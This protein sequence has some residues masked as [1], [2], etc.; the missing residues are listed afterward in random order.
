MTR[1]TRRDRA[2][3]AAARYAI[4]PILALPLPW[5]VHRAGF[6]LFAPRPPGDVRTREHRGRIA[7]VPVLTVEP[8]DR[9]GTL[10]W[11]HG[12]GFVVGSPK[13]NRAMAHALARR[14]GLRVILPDYRKAP[15]HPFPAGLDDC[16]AVTRAV[17]KDGP[18]RLGGDSAGG[19]LALAVCAEMLVEGRGPVRLALISPA[20]DLDPARVLPEG[21]DEMVLSEAALR[22]MVADYLA[23][24]DPGDPRASPV[25]ATFRNPPPTLI[26]AAR[27]E[28]LERD[29]DA[30]AQRLRQQGGRVRVDKMPGMPHDYQILVGLAPAADRSVSRLAIFLR[31]GR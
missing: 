19:N 4:R 31:G 2:V 15:E 8:K 30:I 10:V 27:G 16:L 22:R 18:Y 13:A 29:A 9:H 6:D 24:G 11:F 21:A 1:L 17:A 3:A 28:Y 7:G 26:Q 25:H 12:G 20:V 23:G 5:P 14:G